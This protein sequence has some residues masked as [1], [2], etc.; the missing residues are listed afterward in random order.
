MVRSTF[1]FGP[2]ATRA[3]L[4]I[5][6]LPMAFAAVAGPTFAAA[7]D[8]DGAYKLS[9]TQ[10]AV[11]PRSGSPSTV[12]TFSVRATFKAG[13]PAPKVT[14]VLS[15][16]SSVTHGLAA[17]ST[18]TVGTLFSGARTLPVGSWIV[19]FR[20]VAP[21]GTIVTITAQ[22]SVVITAPNPTPTPAPTPTPTPRPTAPPPTPPP[23][24]PPPT[25]PPPTAPPPTSFPSEPAPT[26]SAAP[27]PGPSATAPAP[28]GHGPGPS[29]SAATLVPAGVIDASG[30]P[31][32]RVPP[33]DPRAGAGG[34][35]LR[36]P[37]PDSPS[38]ADAA[39]DI[40]FMLSV[41]VALGGLGAAIAA[42]LLQ[43]TPAI[44]SAIP[45]PVVA[46]TLGTTRESAVEPTLPAAE[47]ANELPEPDDEERFVPRWRRPSVQ[48][49]RFSDPIK[50]HA[51]RPALRFA[52]AAA[53]GV[54]RFEIRYRS[55]RIGSD[56][57]DAVSQELGRL[58]L[59]DEVELLQRSRGFAQV[60]IPGGLVGW[61]LADTLVEPS[62]E[63]APVDD[64]DDWTR[65]LGTSGVV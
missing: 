26:S 1:R 65:R 20:A 3:A 47:L 48:K 9:L 55:V 37:L 32:A 58:D 12:I 50:D 52:E 13:C 63:V 23:T 10:P 62:L 34:G 59:G 18:N 36:A 56:P 38:L 53:A 2:L 6:T 8:S 49:A 45:L 46:A 30:P 29:P 24:A 39:P 51:P 33:G 21:S 16:P 43:R 19:G 60:R 31:G 41:W 42:V 61:V 54:A 14:A 25:L 15:G 27:S 17:G 57:V 11:S 64:P 7:C 4:V 35:D 5:A 40:F 28:S 44:A 22:G